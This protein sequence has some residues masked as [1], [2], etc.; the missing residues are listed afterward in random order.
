M[1]NIELQPTEV[2]LYEGTVK[3]NVHKGWLALTL[4]SLQM[5]LE[6]EKGVFK[7]EKEVVCRVPLDSIKLYNN[8]VQVKQK[9]WSYNADSRN[10]FGY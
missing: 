1:P 4:T 5:V 6:K 7:K 10:E 9:G 2:I 8:E 3:C